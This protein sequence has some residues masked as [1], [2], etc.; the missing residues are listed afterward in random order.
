MFK[1][2]RQDWIRFFAVVIAIVAG[3]YWLDSYVRNTV[4]PGADKLIKS[5]TSTLVIDQAQREVMKEIRLRLNRPD[6]SYKW[7]V[8][9]LPHD[10]YRMS[11]MECS[12]E[13]GEQICRPFTAVVHLSV[14]KK[15]IE[16]IRM[17]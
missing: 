8:V 16:E 4:R 5:L 17:H 11:S 3:C 7:E 14:D 6:F 12:M 15:Q 13:V 10:R 9:P 1:I 2:E